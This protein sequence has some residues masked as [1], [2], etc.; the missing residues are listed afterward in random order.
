[1]EAHYSTITA[2]F[3][4]AAYGEVRL[5]DLSA[6][7]LFDTGMKL[8]VVITVLT[9]CTWARA[10]TAGGPTMA[11]TAA[12][13]PD[14]GVMGDARDIQRLGWSFNPMQYSAGYV[15]GTLTGVHK[16]GYIVQTLE[17]LVKV[18]AASTSGG[19]IN[20]YCLDRAREKLKQGAGYPAQLQ[21]AEQNCTVQL[22]PWPFSS[23]NEYLLKKLALIGD[24][25][26]VLFY[27]SYFWIPFVQSHNLLEKIYLVD[28][29]VLPPKAS[30][31]VP[32][33]VM[34]YV[35]RLITGYFIGR[36]VKAS[37]DNVVRKAHQI[38]IQQ[39]VGGAIYNQMSVPNRKLFDFTVRAMATGKYMRIF[40]Y[41][42]ME[43]FAFPDN[44]THGYKTNH[45]VYKVQLLN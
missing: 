29:T 28:P 26:V 27:K 38:V 30:F 32:I 25:E 42:L 7:L 35:P 8:L 12:M 3:I 13:D 14:S 11:P 6:L 22:N 19:Y 15:L 34:A 36:V 43:P 44:I 41:K 4:I 33:P 2:M 5:V 45:Y 10:Q 18:G 31:S 24:S 1:M 37:L 16:N 39:G 20:K 21:A 9:V 40:Y 17:G 23:E